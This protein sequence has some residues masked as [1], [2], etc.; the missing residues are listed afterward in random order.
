MW[1][2]TYYGGGPQNTPVWTPPP[3]QPGRRKWW[4]W[5]PLAIV[6]LFITLIIL[7]NII[8]ATGHGH[9]GDNDQWAPAPTQSTPTP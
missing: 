8:G 6:G 2:A 9:H 4:M 3:P 1:W 5:A 7:L